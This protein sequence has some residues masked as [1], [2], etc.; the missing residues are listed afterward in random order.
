MGEILASLK[1]VASR[2]RA[3]SETGNMSHDSGA[4]EVFEDLT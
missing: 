4:D 2:N 3:D 1:F